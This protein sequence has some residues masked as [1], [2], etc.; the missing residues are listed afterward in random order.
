MGAEKARADAR[1]LVGGRY[2]GVNAASSPRYC[3]G[4]DGGV[5]YK[6]RGDKLWEW[7]DDVVGRQRS[8]EVLSKLR[9]ALVVSA[10]LHRPCARIHRVPASGKEGAEELAAGF[11]RAVGNDSGRE[12]DRVMEVTLPTL[13]WRMRPDAGYAVAEIATERDLQRIHLQM[14]S[15][16]NEHH[17]LAAYVVA[18]IITAVVWF[19]RICV[20]L[21]R[22]LSARKGEGHERGGTLA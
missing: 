19:Q 5:T 6:A 3:F 10:H 1:K 7:N 21:S 14:C 15:L 22:S 18:L 13:A 20:V 8:R 16:P 17:V 12:E 4:Q 9:P 11:Q 2:V